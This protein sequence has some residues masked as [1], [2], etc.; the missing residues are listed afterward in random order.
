MSSHDRSKVG[1][2][3]I[4][5]GVFGAIVM[6]PVVGLMVGFVIAFSVPVIP[7]LAAMFVVYW[8]GQGRTPSLLKPTTPSV[9]RPA[10]ARHA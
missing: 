2:V 6:L 5:I 9:W 3:K 8:H 4:A 1:G 10:L 7:L